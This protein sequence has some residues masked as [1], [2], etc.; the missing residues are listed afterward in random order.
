MAK[1]KE[2][3]LDFVP[4][5]NGQNTWDRGEDGVVTIHMVNR[6]FYNTLAQKLFHTPRVSHIKLD[7][8]GSF[9]WTRIDGRQDGGPAG[10][11]AEGGLWGEG[12]AAVRPAGE[13]YA[14]FTQ[15]PLYPVCGKGPGEGMSFGQIVLGILLFALAT[16][17]LYVW[18]LR[19][20]MTQEADL[21]RILLN[22]CAGTVV[23]YLRKHGSITQKELP[24]LIQGVKA[25]MF[26]SKNRIRVQDPAA[27]APKLIR[28]MLEQ[29]LLEDAGGLRYRLRK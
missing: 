17:V 8:Y 22:K 23:K 16:A 9:L 4:A 6:G 28:Y 12:G 29:Q 15:Q 18:G 3:Y 25:G 11:G 20:S 7:E 1:K 14:D 24:A 26:W 5:V 13:I 10:P 19:K 21:E 27:F 2:N